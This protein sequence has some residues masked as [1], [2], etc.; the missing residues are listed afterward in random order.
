MARSHSKTFSLGR[1]PLTSLQVEQLVECAKKGRSRARAPYS[2]QKVGAAVLASD[3]SVSIGCNIEN[4]S[5]GATT[6]A[7]QVALFKAISDG[8]NKFKAVAVI[9]SGRKRPVP[10]GICRQVIWELAGDVEVLV[11]YAGQVDRFPLSQIYP[12]PYEKQKK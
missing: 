6:C 4:V 3:G 5:Y 2:G 12:Q 11:I 8:K 10:C 9:A 1:T 7:E